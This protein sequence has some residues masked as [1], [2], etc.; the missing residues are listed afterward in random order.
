M[1][2]WKMLGSVFNIVNFPQN[3]TTC[4]FPFSSQASSYTKVFFY[5]DYFNLHGFYTHL[6]SSN[7][8]IYDGA[9]LQVLL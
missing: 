5:H 2:K 8:H 6:I 7:W 3:F 9:S 1:T 4:G